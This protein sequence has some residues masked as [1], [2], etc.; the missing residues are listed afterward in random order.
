MFEELLDKFASMN[1]YYRFYPIEYFF[2]SL[3]KN[4]LK[5]FELWTCTHHIDIND[6]SY[7][8]SKKLKRLMKNYQV[9][10]VC[11]TP[12]QSN[13]KPYNLA[14]KEKSLQDKTKKY[15]KNTVQVANELEIPKLSLNSG[16][17]FYSE[18]PHEA[19][20]R[21]IE[22][23]NVIT[24]YAKEK[25]IMVVFEALQ[26]DESQLVNTINDLVTYLRQVNSDNLFINLDL[27]A[28]AKANETIEQ[29]FLT[30]KDKI[31][32]CHF[33]DGAPTGHLAWGDGTRNV[34]D[35][36]YSLKENGYKGYLTFEFANS[37]YFNQ[38]FETDRKVLNYIKK[39]CKE[40]E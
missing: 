1:Y 37:R 30:F 22:M 36:F 6:V 5:N 15:L 23:M 2:S 21:S 40:E 9:Q 12:E 3:H 31:K 24:E 4:N 29:Y 16:W 18:N 39:V 28:M 32:H 26:P 35:D 13:P 10:G 19:W 33:V 7:E 17:N 20:D 34:Y 11:I 38:P 27:G 14:A 25:G 8:D